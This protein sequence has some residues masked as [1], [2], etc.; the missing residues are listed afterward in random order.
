MK[1]FVKPE[2]AILVEYSLVLFTSS[3]ILTVVLLPTAKP[4]VGAIVENIKVVAKIAKKC[5]FIFSSLFTNN[6]KA[7]N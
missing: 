5:F 7:I 6:L 2:S 3:S 4:N 1:K